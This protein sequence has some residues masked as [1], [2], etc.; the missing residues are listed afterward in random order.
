M[1]SKINLSRPYFWENLFKFVL[2]QSIASCPCPKIIVSRDTNSSELGKI[3]KKLYFSYR[4]SR[5][6]TL[7]LHISWIITI[8]EEKW[9]RGRLM[10]WIYVTEHRLQRRRLR[11]SK[12]QSALEPSGN[13]D[14][15]RVQEAF[16]EHRCSELSYP[17][18][19]MNELR[20]AKVIRSSLLNRKRWREFERSASWPKSV[21]QYILYISVSIS[22]PIYWVS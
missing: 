18:Q 14:A 4:Y 7:T 2:S 19:R 8:Q 5:Y 9:P 1:T 16:H 13:V 15:T 17:G 10:K 22:R 11:E 6:Y 20:A 21:G 12:A 3:S